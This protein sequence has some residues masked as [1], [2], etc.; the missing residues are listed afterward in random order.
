MN[1]ASNYIHP[2][3]HRITDCIRRAP[4]SRPRLT[5][6]D[7][8]TRPHGLAFGV[9]DGARTRDLRSHKW[10]V[11]AP[12]AAGAGLARVRGCPDEGGPGGYRYTVPRDPKETRLGISLITADDDDGDGAEG[13]DAGTGAPAQDEDDEEGDVARGIARTDERAIEGPLSPGKDAIARSRGVDDEGSFEDNDPE[14]EEEVDCL[15]ELTGRGWYRAESAIVTE[16]VPEGAPQGEER[17]ADALR[18]RVPIYHG[19][20]AK[21]KWHV[22]DDTP[23]VLSAEELPGLEAEEPPS[24]VRPTTPEEMDARLRRVISLLQQEAHRFYDPNFDEWCFES[25][26]NA[27]PAWQTASRKPTCTPNF[28]T[29]RVPAESCGRWWPCEKAGGCRRGRSRRPYGPASPPG[30]RRTRP[31][32]KSPTT[33]SS[34]EDRGRRRGSP[35]TPPPS[36]DAGPRGE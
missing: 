9:T 10:V 15:G 20:R 2:M 22:G 8:L 17:V 6:C 35:P 5:I 29:T 7:L 33:I 11:G 13:R 24:G 25:R 19:G 23:L 31:S 32:W 36:P 34:S 21:R 16:N 14:E 26:I 18:R 3:S 30:T 1:L 27:S 12:G 4:E 28:G